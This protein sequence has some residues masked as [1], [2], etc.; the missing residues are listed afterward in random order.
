MGRASS[1]SLGH[2]I[3]FPRPTLS[4]HPPIRENLGS[5]GTASPPTTDA[6]WPHDLDTSTDDSRWPLVPLSFAP[7]CSTQPANPVFA[8]AADRRSSFV[9]T[10]ESVPPRDVDY[11]QKIP[12]GLPVNKHPLVRLFAS[13]TEM[14]CD[15]CTPEPAGLPAS[16]RFDIS[17][18][19]RHCASRCAAPGPLHLLHLARPSA[20]LSPRVLTVHLQGPAGA[21]SRICPY[22][23]R[24]QTPGYRRSSR[25]EHVCRLYFFSGLSPTCAFLHAG[26]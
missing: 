24:D 25:P 20:W 8:P 6:E 12:A 2:Y 14:S 7:T 23:G 19:H 1:G 21:E 5:G 9:P 17:R 22:P 4:R 11:R 15:R 13:A 3:F 16:R 18:A 26:P 10:P